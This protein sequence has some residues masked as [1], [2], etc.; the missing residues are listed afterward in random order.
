MDVCEPRDRSVGE[1]EE[2]TVAERVEPVLRAGA[3]GNAGERPRDEAVEV[4]VHKVRVEDVRAAGSDGA[5]NARE[6]PGARGAHEPQ[7]VDA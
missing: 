1:P 5:E 7:P 3:D 6:R 4:G 2:A